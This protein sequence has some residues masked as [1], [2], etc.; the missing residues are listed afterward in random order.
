MEALIMPLGKLKL[1]A[2]DRYL[3]LYDVSVSLVKR[4]NH[5]IVSASG[6]H[7]LCGT[8]FDYLIEP[9]SMGIVALNG[10]SKKTLPILN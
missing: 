2:P 1:Y 3:T 6:K 9:D 8:S 10:H 5:L 4:N 7:N